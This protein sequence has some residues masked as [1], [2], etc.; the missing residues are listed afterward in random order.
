MLTLV[1]FGLQPQ[2][3]I[4]IIV[5]LIMILM[6]FFY[7]E[8]SPEGIGIGSLARGARKPHKPYPLPRTPKSIMILLNWSRSDPIS[9]IVKVKTNTY[10]GLFDIEFRRNGGSR[11]AKG[12]ARSGRFGQNVNGLRP[13]F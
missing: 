10:R 7:F 5:I 9:T 3:R 4:M 12:Q 6:F 11:V 1:I 8:D 13:I 2:L